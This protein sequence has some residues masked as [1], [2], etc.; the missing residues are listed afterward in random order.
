MALQQVHGRVTL[1]PQWRQDAG[2][3][4]S[5][6]ILSLRVDSFEAGDAG[7]KSYDVELR[8]THI[9]GF[10][11]A[12]DEVDVFAKRGGQPLKGRAIHNVNTHAWVTADSGAPP[13]EDP[14]PTPDLA[15]PATVVGKPEFRTETGRT[16][17]KTLLALRAEWAGPNGAVRDVEMRPGLFESGVQGTVQRG[18]QVTIEG[19][20]HNNILR[21][22]RIRIKATGAVIE[23]D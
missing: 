19:K 17:T 7:I 23:A 10:V 9:Y 18:D 11:R 22:K 1:D 21:A 12:G 4:L 16:G 8:G 6:A 14:A 2:Q 20:W 15:T 13:E 5:T 3:E